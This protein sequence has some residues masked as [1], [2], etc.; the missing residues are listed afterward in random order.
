MKDTVLVTG[1]TGKTGIHIVQHLLDRGLAVR[2]LS[3]NA[4]LAK[5]KFDKRVSIFTGDVRDVSTIKAPMEGVT[6]VIATPPIPVPL[7]QLVPS[8]LT[9]KER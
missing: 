9:M 5:G 4:E 1:G 8:I 2:V 6:G 7:A 3:R